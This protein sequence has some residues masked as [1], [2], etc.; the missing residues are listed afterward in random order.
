ME[1]LKKVYGIKIRKPDLGFMFNVE[2]G[3]EKLKSRKH[4]SIRTAYLLAI[5]LGPFG[6]H[7]FYLN[8]WFLGFV[9]LCT[10]GILGVGWI[11][12]LFRISSLVEDENDNDETHRNNKNLLD[13]Y[14][15]WFPCG[16]IGEYGAPKLAKAIGCLFS[17]VPL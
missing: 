10:F 6:A 17:L 14:L 2:K 4:K 8:R 12:D 16:I 9:Y 15:V 3:L 1:K 7:H 11:L 13:A 5:F